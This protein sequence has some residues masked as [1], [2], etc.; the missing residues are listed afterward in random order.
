MGP[1]SRQAQGRHSPCAIKSWGTYTH[2]S[3]RRRSCPGSRLAP[4]PTPKP[5]SLSVLRT[6]P[7]VPGFPSFSPCPLPWA[8]IL[9]WLFLS[10]AL[11]CLAMKATI[12]SVRHLSPI[13]HLTSDSPFRAVSPAAEEGMDLGQSSSR[14]AHPEQTHGPLTGSPVK[15]A[16]PRPAGLP[17]APRAS[18]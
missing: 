9:F 16:P 3:Q 5:G 10:P 4:V 11:G 6:P 18:C 8:L 1:P 15:P 7:H 14:N 17:A 12:Y 2:V 13:P